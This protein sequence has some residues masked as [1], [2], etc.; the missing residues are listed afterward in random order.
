MLVLNTN[1]NAH[2]A[3]QLLDSYVHHFRKILM[4]LSLIIEICVRACI[5]VHQLICS[6]LN[7]QHLLAAYNVPS[8]FEAQAQ[9]I[10]S[11][12]FISILF[13]FVCLLDHLPL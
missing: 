8:I 7:I 3:S 9:R 11:V 6:T 5:Y 4:L 1:M 2:V 12:G 10:S 13:L